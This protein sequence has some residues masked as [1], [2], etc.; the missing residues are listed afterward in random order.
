MSSPPTV[1]SRR[2]PPP[3]RRISPQF[4]WLMIL[5]S[6]VPL[7][8]LQFPREVSYWFL[9]AA[10]K[11]RSQ[12]N[13]EL[14][15]ERLEKAFSWNPRDPWLQVQQAKWLFEDEKYLEA[16]K[17]SDQLAERFPQDVEVLELRVA[18]LQHLERHEEAIA[19][20][21][22][23]DQKSL[24]SGRPDRASALNS[25]AYA[26]AVGNLELEQALKEANEALVIAP[27]MPAYLDTRG[28]ILYRLGKHKEAHVDLDAAVKGMPKLQQR[29]AAA[30]PPDS[31]ERYGD[32][33]DAYQS[34]E[35]SLKTATAV[36]L[37]HR[38]LNLEKLGRF[39]EAKLD[40]AQVK[41]LIGREP[42]ETLF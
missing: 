37:Y 34:Y 4:L 20:A 30:A 33:V 16:L 1:H 23:L 13:A 3:I 10:E 5:V 6:L 39:A 11:A 17:V 40:R 28:F 31:L 9:A 35:Q 38:A 22:A 7:A 42:D 15:S 2:E 29:A 36:L 26:R 12:G 19:L 21:R 18:I 24:T 41:R 14:A 32:G 8:Y 27:R 25:L